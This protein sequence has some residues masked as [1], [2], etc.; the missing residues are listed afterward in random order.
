MY[1]KGGGGIDSSKGGGGTDSS[2]SVHIVGEQCVP[3]VWKNFLSSGSNKDRLVKYYS[4]F[5]KKNLFRS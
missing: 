3:T 4:G 1:E 2:R 5:C